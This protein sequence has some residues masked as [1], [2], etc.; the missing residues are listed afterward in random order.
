MKRSTAAALFAILLA[1]VLVRLLPILQYTYWGSDFGEYYALTRT[2][3]QTGALPSH[4]AGW[5]FTY[6]YFPG[7]FALNAAFVVLGAPVD[8]VVVLLV[9][10][11][12]GFAVLPVF[13]ITVRVVGDDFA[14]LVAASFLGVAFLHA[15]STSHAIPASLGDLLLLGALLQFLGLRRSPK[16]FGLLVLTGLAIVVT[17]HFATYF[18]LLAVVSALLLRAILDRTLT[19]RA[20]RYELAFLAIL[21]A[22]TLAFWA[23]YAV[24]FWNSIVTSLPT[25]SLLLVAGVGAVALVP[26][27][28]R[29]RRRWQ[30]RFRPRL[31]SVRTAG[32]AAGIAFGTSCAIVAIASAA[33][34][35]GTTIR[36]DLPLLAPFLPLF[37]FFS[38]SAAGR[39]VLDVSRDGPGVT[40][41][42]LAIVASIFAGALAAPQV[43]IPYR[44]LEYLALPV[45]VMVGTGVRWLSL[46]LA[47]PRRGVAIAAA[48]VLL[49][50]S[51]SLS[52]YPP[53]ATLAGF[54]EGIDAR[55]VE[56]ALWVRTHADGLVAG[57]HRESTVL[58]GI[59]GVNATWD[60]ELRFWHTTDRTAALEAMRDVQVFGRT[61]RVDWVLIDRDLRA[62]LQATPYD[63]A[64][65]LLP[66]EE[67]KFMASP[68]QKVYDSGFAQ[69]YYVNWGLAP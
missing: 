19:L 56:A 5:G 38:F 50:A 57:D 66:A 1:A 43:L 14:G 22:A 12:V 60:F 49:V 59:G 58:F 44:H 23:L 47:E 54:Q 16:F 2:L 63:P 34:I 53:P 48:T 8:A 27:V 39:K 6:P 15:F 17:H 30:W 62:G 69:V 32:L 65:P 25:S 46:G 10:I 36:L 4:Y 11:L 64:L 31:H 61:E 37:A 41:W 55:T 28:I 33:P 7:M 45:A 9:P 42:F 21:V 51:T 20:V 52:T 29:L 18:L 24:P 68:F 3:A 67:A 35:P 26:V 40:A 13:L